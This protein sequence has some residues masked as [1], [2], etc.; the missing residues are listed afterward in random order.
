M[1]LQIVAPC[2]VHLYSGGSGV[3][4]SSIFSSSLPKS[5]S[6]NLRKVMRSK[7]LITSHLPD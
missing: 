6:R 4:Y 5:N 1:A 7:V 2:I 3:P